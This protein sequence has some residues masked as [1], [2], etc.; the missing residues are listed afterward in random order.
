MEVRAL[1]LGGQL[2]PDVIAAYNDALDK[3][4]QAREAAKGR[5][6]CIPEQLAEGRCQENPDGTLTFFTLPGDAN[7]H[8]TEEGYTYR[9]GIG[10]TTKAEA[11]QRFHAARRAYTTPMERFFDDTVNG[12]TKVADFAVKLPGI[13]SV[14][15]DVYKTF[16]PPTSE[17]YSGSGLSCLHSRLSILKDD[18]F[19]V[20]HLDPQSKS[21]A[22]DAAILA[23]LKRL[24]PECTFVAVATPASLK[25]AH[26]MLQD[27][28]IEEAV[29]LGPGLVMKPKSIEL[30]QGGGWFES[31]LTKAKEVL[32]E[33][34]NR[35]ASIAKPVRQDYPPKVRK[36]LQEYGNE[37]IMALAVIRTPIQS[38]ISR[39]LNLITAGQ[40]ESLKAKYGYD[41]FMHLALIAT[42]PKG[43][44][45]IQKNEV[46]DISPSF[47]VKPTTQSMPVEL[48]HTPTVSQFLERGKELMGDKFFTYSALGGNNCQN[49][50]SSLL[51]ANGFITE[52]LQSFV[53]QPVDSILK[54]LPGFVKPL[55]D[56]VTTTAAK[57]NELFE[58]QG[59]FKSRPRRNKA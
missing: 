17:Y 10:W 28:H 24:H 22:K 7:Y 30:L 15:K 40:W 43:Q 5:A 18:N 16:A 8:D 42:T 23:H 11:G 32:T 36:V 21:Y 25:D 46:I 55:T 27:G 31:F 53:F 13:S 33:G 34:I 2:D 37:P 4:R 57:F 41:E 44:L 52:E 45:I 38:F 50:I 54:E 59:K 12:L 58:G 19:I 14:A 29:V 47:Q 35:V 48:S 49:F 3:Q 51:K 6:P 26:R 56:V 1:L 39:F 20:V 9:K